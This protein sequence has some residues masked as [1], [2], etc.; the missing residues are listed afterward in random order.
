MSY[1]NKWN[2]GTISM[3]REA[4]NKCRRLWTQIQNKLTVHP[5]QSTNTTCQAVDFPSYIAN[6]LL[7]FGFSF[8]EKEGQIKYWSLHKC[9][10]M[11]IKTHTS[12]K[13]DI[14]LF[15]C[16]TIVSY[17]CFIW[18][19]MLMIQCTCTQKSATK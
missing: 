2:M 12:I 8:S 9:V 18:K 11:C 19:I 3:R 15:L 14:A 6:F 7:I 13:E 5:S 16:K 1:R 17:N 10:C 4:T